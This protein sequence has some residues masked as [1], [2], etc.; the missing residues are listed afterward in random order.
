MLFHDSSGEGLVG[1]ADGS[2]ALSNIDSVAR[3]KKIVDA[4]VT[5]DIAQVT[6][7]GQAPGLGSRIIASHLRLSPSSAL[8]ILPTTASLNNSGRIT[9]KA[10]IFYQY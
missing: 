4:A 6:V 5:V 10:A 1:V 2:N 3:Q 8:T 7:E 9:R